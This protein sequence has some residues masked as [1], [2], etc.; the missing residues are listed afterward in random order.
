MNTNK[1]N[2]I[3]YQLSRKVDQ[4]LQMSSNAKNII[5]TNFCD[6]SPIDFEKVAVE[7]L[8]KIHDNVGKCVDW[9]NS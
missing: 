4:V 3:V 9:V 7:Q 2:I 8:K 1:Q 5:E 6:G